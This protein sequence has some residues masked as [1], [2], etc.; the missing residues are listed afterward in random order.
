VGL[1]AAVRV[2]YD[3]QIFTMQRHGGI[4]RYFVE[5]I[6]AFMDDAEL[7]VEPQLDWRWTRNAHALE[8][9]LG[10][11]LRIPGGSRGRPLRWANRITNVRRPTVDVVHRT[12]YRASYLTRGPAAPSVVTVY[13]MTPE[14]FPE[15]F[16]K[17]NPHREKRE[18]VDRARAVICISESTRRDMISL[19]GPPTAPIIVSHLGVRKVFSPGAA[20]PPWCPNGYLLFVGARDGYK[21]F[22]VALESFAEIAA[23]VSG[24]TLLAVGGGTFTPD[25]GALISRWGLRGRVLQH[26][27]S[28]AELPGIFG[29]AQAFVFPSRYEGF[30]LPTLEAMACGAP[31]VLADSSSHPEVGGEAALYFPPGDSSA[32][33][34]QL[35]RLIS[36]DGLWSALAANGIA[37]ARGFTWRHTA[38]ATADAYRMAID[39]GV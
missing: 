29:G 27:A 12:F 39:A 9:G 16:P 21:D 8:A 1:A 14:L 34:A 6:R 35:S 19:Y 23:T 37:R 13:D 24:I 38:A 32:L 26:E 17:E 30:G 20:R 5:L 36:D 4:S 15:L 3:D 2:C 22:Q 18:F 11:S 28:D 33:T 31:V 25:E 7:E 10:Q